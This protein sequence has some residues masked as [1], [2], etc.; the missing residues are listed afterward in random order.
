M[1]KLDLGALDQALEAAHQPAL[2][3]A[4]VQMTG[5]LHWLRPEWTPTYTPLSRG[6]T[7]VPEAEQVK[8]RAEA[9]AAILDWVAKGSPAPATPDPA[10]LRRMM[11]FVA[12]AD[13][14]EN[15]ADFLNDELAIGGHSSKD[16]QW[17][18]PVL[19][20]A[21]RL[22]E[23]PVYNATLRTTC[24]VTQISGGHA[25][26]ALPQEARALINCRAL[27]GHAQADVERALIAVVA[28]PSVEVVARR[29]RESSAPARIDAK[30]LVAVT[31][32]AESLW[33]GVPVIPIMG[34]GATDSTYFRLAGIP[35]YGVSGLFDDI[36]DYRAHGRDERL[37]VA[38]FYDGLEFLRRLVRELAVK[39]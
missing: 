30:F 21:A 37:G 33:P 11:S 32:V 12:G 18:T 6:E 31:R 39:E 7:G 25:P 26:N 2:S 8:F 9:K 16:P 20:A 1:A 22:S 35:A 10:A 27:P 15:Y 4:L 3:A 29:E 5:D 28:D 23:A 38:A 13:I 14:P 17:T 19:Q 34:T 24:T 36:D